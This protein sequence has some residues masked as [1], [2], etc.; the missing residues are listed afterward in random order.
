MRRKKS[1]SYEEGLLERL[2]NPKHASAYLMACLEDKEGDV[3]ER[4]LLALRDVARAHGF[5]DLSK[6]AKLGRESL[7]KTISDKGNPKLSTVFSIL[8]AMDLELN[9]HPK[10]AA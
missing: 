8:D 2:K 4:F 3:E 10:K 6:K 7:Y 1:V 5:A 9:I